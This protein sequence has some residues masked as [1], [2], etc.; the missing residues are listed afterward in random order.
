MPE[1]KFSVM[2]I[3]STSVILVASVLMMAACTGEKNS[4]LKAAELGVNAKAV[5]ST[6]SNIACSSEDLAV[7]DRN[8]GEVIDLDRESLPRGLFL[9]TASEMLIEKKTDTGSARALVREVIG[10]KGAEITCSEAVEKFGQD[11]D[12]VMTGLVKFETTE[13]SLGSGFVSRQFFFFQDKNGYG[14]V[15]SNPKPSAQNNDLKK[16]LRGGVPVGQ[17]VRMSDR[18]YLLKYM[19]ER[20]GVRARLLVRLELVP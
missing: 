15:L 2:S 20:D 12:M 6:A 19:R 7:F 5:A 14:V 10:G 9:A 1:E 4:A 16:Y 3:S 17:L 11:F 8:D 18:S 13:K